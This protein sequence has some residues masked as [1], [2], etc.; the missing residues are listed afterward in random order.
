MQFLL[1]QIYRVV[2]IDGF[3]RYSVFLIFISNE[4]PLFMKHFLTI[5]LLFLVLP[6]LMAEKRVDKTLL[7]IEKKLWYYTQEAEEMLDSLRVTLTEKELKKHSAHLNYLNGFL[8]YQKGQIDT[9]L[10][11]TEKALLTFAEIQNKAGQGKCHLLLGWIA[12][13][14]TQWH[15]AQTNYFESL[16]LLDEKSFKEKGFANLGIGRCKMALKEPSRKYIKN[17]RRLL[18]KTNQREYSLYADLAKSWFLEKS[19]PQIPP[20]LNKVAEEY[21]QMGLNNNAANVYKRLTIYY[22]SSVCKPD[23]VHYYANLGIETYNNNYPGVSLVPSFLYMKGGVYL[24]QGEIE[25]A[26]TYLNKSVQM[27]DKTGFESYKYYPLVFLS[28][29]H[30]RNN[31]FQKAYNTYREAVDI[32]EKTH[33]KERMRMARIAETSANVKLLNEEIN[34][35]IRNHTKS[36][37]IFILLIALL[38]VISA[39]V[40]LMFR[41][42]HLARQQR[43]KNHNRELQSLLAGSSEKKMAIRKGLIGEVLPQKVKYNNEENL[44][45]KFQACY[46][47][48]I[49]IFSENFPSL[50]HSETIYA[51][52]FALHYSNDTIISIQNIQL[53][54]IRKIKQRI[55]E[56]LALKNDTNLEKFFEKHTNQESFKNSQ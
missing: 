53:S 33:S 42:K 18:Y 47:E 4:I 20:L 46:R 5:G 15:Q 32:K 9:A 48:N 39:I 10:N 51:L 31:Q 52:M 11:F 23:S 41:Q 30:A 29:L 22:S 55:R 24:K 54:T 34:N 45:E 3:H 37:I 35:L 50:S 19:D 7:H 40:F 25:M 17:G 16:R 43:V 49:Q 38:L 1:T 36:K 27:C 28:N 56:K 13:G 21:I 26:E 6:S 8:T 14:E 2:K 12:E 44:K